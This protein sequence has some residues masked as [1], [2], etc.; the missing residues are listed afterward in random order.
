MQKLTPE[1]EWYDKI[2]ESLLKSEKIEA[3]YDP[4]PDGIRERTNSQLKHLLSL[5]KAYNEP[6]TNEK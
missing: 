6:R 2:A 3:K 5:F 4:E 1:Q